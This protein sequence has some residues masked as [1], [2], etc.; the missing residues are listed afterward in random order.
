[1]VPKTSSAHLEI[2]LLSITVRDSCVEIMVIPNLRAIINNK[3]TSK[4]ISEILNESSWRQRCFQL[5]LNIIMRRSLS[6]LKNNF[7]IGIYNLVVCS[8]DSFNEI[9]EHMNLFPCI[10]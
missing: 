7:K 4:H 6:E 8:N 1:M 3:K 5:T 2:V 10:S 9:L